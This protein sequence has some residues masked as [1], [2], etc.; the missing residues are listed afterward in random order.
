M[1]SSFITLTFTAACL[2]GSS[3]ARPIPDSI[4]DLLIPVDWLWYALHSGL[5]SLENIHKIDRLPDQAFDDTPASD[6]SPKPDAPP[7]RK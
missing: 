5:S 4:T 1:R 2:L 3:L 6:D 7:T